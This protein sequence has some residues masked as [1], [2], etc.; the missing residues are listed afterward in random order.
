MFLEG[1]RN[2]RLELIDIMDRKAKR[3]KYKN[4]TAVLNFEIK[5]LGRHWFNNGIENKFVYECPG[6]GWLRGKITWKK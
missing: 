4:E 3:N 1:M 2:I 5:S 6:E